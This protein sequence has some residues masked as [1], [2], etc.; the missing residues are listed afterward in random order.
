MD[1]AEGSLFWAFPG[2]SERAAKVISTLTGGQAQRRQV[3][4]DAVAAAASAEAIDLAEFEA[5]SRAAA[6]V[7]LLDSDTQS[8]VTLMAEAA[9]EGEAALIALNEAEDI[10]KSEAILQAEL[11]A[12]AK[13]GLMK[14]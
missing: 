1:G 11:A 6:E 3:T 9:A 12:K 10:A 14:S 8:E 13:A 2:A 5:A 4:L 7:E